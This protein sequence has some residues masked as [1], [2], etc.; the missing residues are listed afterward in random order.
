MYPTKGIIVLCHVDDFL[1]LGENEAELNKVLEAVSEKV[2]LQDLGEVS[3][4]LGIEFSLE[5]HEETGPTKALGPTKGLKPTKGYKSIK[6]HQTKYTQSI[7]K[8]FGKENLTPVTTPVQ[9]GVK[10]Q[11]ATSDPSKEDIQLY[12][13][14]VGSLMWLSGKTRPDLTY[15]VNNCARYMAKPDK[16]H[17]T[18]LDR[19]WKYLNGYPDLGLYISYNSDIGLI[20]YSD[21]DWANCLMNRKSTT[22]YCFLYNRNLISWNSA[23]QR[24]VAISTCEAEYMA[25]RE[26]T[27]ETIYLSSILKWLEKEKLGTY[28]PTTPPILT[29]SEAALKLANNPEFHKRTKHIDITYHFIRECIKDGKVKVIPVRTTD[30]LADGFTKGLNKHKHTAFIESLNLQAKSS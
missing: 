22:G 15:A 5:K 19:I 20:G 2:K 8:R 18:A 16:S 28:L 29:D 1:A 24:T 14:E 7:L 26:A 12:Q 4:F 17:C 11:K 10:L 9:E 30:Q 6:L 23:L 21:S 3:T 27:K 13:E 25:I